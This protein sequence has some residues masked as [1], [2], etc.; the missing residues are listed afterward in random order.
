MSDFGREYTPA[1]VVTRLIA[2]VVDGV[3]VA[4]M[5][6][7]LFLGVAAVRFLWFPASFTWPRPAL[8]LSA[9]LLF[10]LTSAYLTACWATNGRTVG[11]ALL[12]LRVLATPRHLLGWARAAVRAALCTLFP[13]GLLWAAV[14]SSRR[15]VQDLL[16]RSVVLHDFHPDRGA[17]A[18]AWQ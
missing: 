6:G 13:V 15:S 5:A 7:A 11:G 14:S 12:G 10:A 9:G 17:T 3:V 2:A 16:V 1:G 4:T 8:W 18:A